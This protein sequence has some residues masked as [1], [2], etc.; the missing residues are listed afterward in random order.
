MADCIFHPQ[1]FHYSKKVLMIRVR[2]WMLVP[3]RGQRLENVIVNT[4]KLVV[5]TLQFR[6]WDGLRCLLTFS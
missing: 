1:S 2:E 5:E 3:F 6:E 4:S